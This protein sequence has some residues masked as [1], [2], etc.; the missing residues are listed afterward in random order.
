M[1]DNNQELA[2]DNNAKAPS[3]WKNREIGALWKKSGKTQNYFSGKINVANFNDD[4]SINV[5]GF[6]NTKKS[7]ENSPDVILYTSPNTSNNSLDLDSK[8]SEPSSGDKIED[9]SP[10]I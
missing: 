2:Q 3:E 4:E 7:S 6:A 5:V 1:T 9:E 8:K 10:E